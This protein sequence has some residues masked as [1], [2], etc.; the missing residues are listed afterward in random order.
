M[1][2]SE[3]RIVMATT[4]GRS[5]KQRWAV[6]PAR[7]A[8]VL[9]AVVGL[10]IFL[11]SPEISGADASRTI[12]D[13]YADSGDPGRLA[14]FEPLGFLAVFSFVW[15]V[16]R[17]HRSVAD[18]PGG[19]RYASAI[20]T[21]G[22]V[23]AGL[24]AASFVVYTTVAGTTVFTDAFNVD[25]NTAMLFSH[26]GYVLLAGAMVGASVMVL[27][28]TRAVQALTPERKMFIRTGYVVGVL[29]LLSLMF[30]FLPLIAFAIWVGTAG[31]SLT[32]S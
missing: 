4:T 32:R 20:A 14:M 8:A 29:S 21:G 19:E 2:A 5:V 23:F 27:A 25:A 28:S 26:L 13:F 10:G 3:G 31:A 7:A 22:A 16:A 18:S 1:A 6:P 30:V 11:L 24:S 9:L 15:F 17:L 12:R